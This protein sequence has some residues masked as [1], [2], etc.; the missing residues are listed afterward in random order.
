MS[1]AGLLQQVL[2]D[3]A[4]ADVTD[5]DINACGVTFTDGRKATPSPATE[6]DVELIELLQTLAS[7]VGDKGSS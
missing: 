1:G 3:P 6:T 2:A 5:L 7:Y 4:F